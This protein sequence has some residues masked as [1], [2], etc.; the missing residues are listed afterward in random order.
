M[1]RHSTTKRNRLL[2]LAISAAIAAG[3]SAQTDA[4]FSAGRL[5]LISAARTLELGVSGG[6][7]TSPSEMKYAFSQS[8]S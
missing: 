6:L 8:R 4:A 3:A 1:A 2:A 7:A 5:S